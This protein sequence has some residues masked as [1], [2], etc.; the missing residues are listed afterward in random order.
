[1]RAYWG[2][3]TVMPES[4]LF[5]SPDMWSAVREFGDVVCFDVTYNLLKIR[6]I[7]GKSWGVGIFSGFGSNLELVIFGVSII[8]NES[9]ESLSRLFA[10]YLEMTGNSRPCIITD[11]QLSIKSSL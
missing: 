1:M 10:N 2:I 11:E 7:N 4:F 6:N 3:E 5:I 8:N 9:T